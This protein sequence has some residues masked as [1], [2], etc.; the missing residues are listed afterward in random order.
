MDKVSMVWVIGKSVQ[1]VDKKMEK[2]KDMT[3]C[4]L[5]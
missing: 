1:G 3:H 5:I 2:P 4:K